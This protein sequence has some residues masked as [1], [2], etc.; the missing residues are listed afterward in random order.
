MHSD[1]ECITVQNS[2]AQCSALL[3]STVRCSTADSLVSIDEGAVASLG[4]FITAMAP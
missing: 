2:T 3:Y 4:P 1:V